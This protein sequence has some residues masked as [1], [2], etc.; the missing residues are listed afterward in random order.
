MEIKNRSTAKGRGVAFLRSG[1][2]A[3]LWLILAITIMKIL[4]VKGDKIFGEKIQDAFLK[5]KDEYKV[6]FILISFSICAG[7]FFGF[8]TWSMLWSKICW[9]RLAYIDGDKLRIFKEQETNL[10]NADVIRYSDIEKVTSAFGRVFL[11]L[12]TNKTINIDCSNY[13]E[14]ANFLA[15]KINQEPKASTSYK[16]GI[17]FKH[18]GIILLCTLIRGSIFPLWVII[19]VSGVPKNK[20]KTWKELEDEK[21]KI[22]KELNSDKRSAELLK[23]L[24]E[25]NKQLNEKNNKK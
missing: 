16:V 25:I 23:K 4:I 2:I 18:I 12:K 5:W 8:I 15:Q 20:S 7:P 22:E 10:N 11:K 17:V 19:L 9:G 13:K 6:W 3:F 1:L 21:I 14:V 24:E